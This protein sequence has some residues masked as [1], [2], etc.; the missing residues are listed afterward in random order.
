MLEIRQSCLRSAMAPLFS[1]TYGFEKVKSIVPSEWR[2]F[3]GLPR[4]IALPAMQWS[5]LRACPAIRV[6]LRKGRQPRAPA[7]LPEH[8][9]SIRSCAAAWFQSLLR[10]LG[11][12]PL[13]MRPCSGL[14]S[15]E[16]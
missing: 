10:G 8:E 13:G 9:R 12:L 7:A 1:I 11:G 15:S 4:A 5:Y 3:S 14:N 2:A 16:H 6:M